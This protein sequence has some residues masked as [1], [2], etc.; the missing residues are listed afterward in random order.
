[1][2]LCLA[3][4]LLEIKTKQTHSNSSKMMKLSVVL[5]SLALFN[6]ALSASIDDSFEK[7]FEDKL[8]ELSRKKLDAVPFELEDFLR[9]SAGQ[10]AKLADFDG[11]YNVLTFRNIY[12][13]MDGGLRYDFTVDVL[14]QPRGSTVYGVSKNIIQRGQLYLVI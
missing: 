9:S 5:L 6:V 4:F 7:A 12:S 8:K 3:F 14:T 10:L 11:W 1:M 13:Q 2:A